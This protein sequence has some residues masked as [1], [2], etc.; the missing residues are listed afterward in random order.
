MKKLIIATIVLVLLT[1]TACDD[2]DAR[3]YATEL[4]GVLKTY[5]VEVNKK[6]TAEKKSYK[7]LAANYAYSK[8]TNMISRLST[9]RLSGADK[10]TD[11][12]MA[13]E[14]FTPSDMHQL[15]FEHA[16]LEFETTR[17]ALEEESDGQAEYLASLEAL[18]FQ[19]QNIAQLTKALEAL[20]KPKSDVKKLKEL[21]ASAKEFK[22]KFDELECDALAEEIACLKAEQSA[23]DKRENLTAEQKKAAKEKLEMQIKALKDLNK[24]QK[25]KTDLDKVKCPDTKG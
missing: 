15:V 23:V 17:Q 7:D 1:Q 3:D 18:D 25:C 4:V 20:S 21:A 13:N 11:L 24:E 5:Q 14:K 10:L 2:K 12:L 9:A 16:M 8:Q 6:I 22:T 19:A